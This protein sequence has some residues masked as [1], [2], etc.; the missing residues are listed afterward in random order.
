V[1]ENW[2]ETNFLSPTRQPAGGGGDLAP[3]WRDALDF[4]RSMWRTTPGASYP[5]GYLGT[6]RSRRDDRLLDS[7]KTRQNQRSYQ[8]GVHKGERID[9]ADYFWPAAWQ[10]DRGLAHEAVGVRQAPVDAIAERLPPAGA[11]IYPRGAQSLATL[12]HT[13]RTVDP[14]RVQQLRRLAPSWR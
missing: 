1:S 5:D 10:P 6:I 8:R 4:N 9:Q 2:A 14:V 11:T 7:L 12:T 13:P 3:W